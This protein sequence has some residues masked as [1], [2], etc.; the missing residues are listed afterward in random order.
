MAANLVVNVVANGVEAVKTGIFGIAI[1][2]QRAAE[3]IKATQEGIVKT[4]AALF[5]LTS[6]SATA[7]TYIGMFRQEFGF[8][9]D[10]I[11]TPILPLLDLVLDAFGAFVEWLD[12]Q[13]PFIKSIALGIAIAFGLMWLGVSGPVA[14]VIAVV[15]AFLA[16]FTQQ[17]GVVQA[18]TT[19][20]AIAFG[21]MWF[22]ATGGIVPLIAALAALA[23][24]VAKHWDQI[25]SIFKA[26][27]QV[28]IGWLQPLIDAITT[29]MHGVGAVAGFV[30]NAVHGVG[31]VLGL[32]GPAP[33]VS[34]GG[35]GGSSPGGG[36]GGV[37]YTANINA[38]SMSGGRDAAL[39]FRSSLAFDKR[40]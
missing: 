38:S 4:T 24:F 35:G 33:A 25:K 39:A 36:G 12:R 19:A 32:S 17:S 31:N 8:F 6:S 1:A 29:V 26:A 21:I 23:I 37:S 16:W 30:G 2:S 27:I 3:K 40:F 7:S 5:V 28:I 13:G 20:I 22:A 9:I 15:A 34:R 18:I 14:V 11:L 10:T